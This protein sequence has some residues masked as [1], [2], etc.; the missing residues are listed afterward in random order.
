MR[1]EETLALLEDK[2]NSLLQEQKKQ[3]EELLERIKGLE[4]HKE[5][6]QGGSSQTRR[7]TTKAPTPAVYSG[8]SAERNSTSLRSFFFRI[9]K[10][11]KFS[12]L[13]DESTLSLAVCH[14]DG[15]AATWFMRTE[16]SAKSPATFEELRKLMF[17]EFVP[18]IEKSQA[19]MDLVA[20]KMKMGDATDKH[21]DKFEE[22][23]ETSKTDMSEAYSFLFM[24]LP[25]EIKEDLTKHFE[26]ETPQDIHE[27][28]RRVRTIAMAKKF[29]SKENDKRQGKPGGKG[30]NYPKPTKQEGQ[31]FKGNGGRRELSKDDVEWGK[32]RNGGERIV[33]RSADRCFECGKKGWSDSEHPCR[34]A[35]DTKN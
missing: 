6:S 10:A 13:D 31:P 24:T 23:M 19:K 17:K 33:Y 5:G 11:A 35:Q 15:R 4:N 28:Y 8:K 21:I 30:T 2:Y 7:V 1:M 14:L 34:K 12:N 29:M 27:A 26:G 20:L 22:L 18:S 16:A 25:E 3:N 9:T 32:A